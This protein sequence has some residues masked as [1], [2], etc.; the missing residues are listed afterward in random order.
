MIRVFV[1]VSQVLGD[2]FCFKTC[3]EVVLRFVSLILCRIVKLVPSL[4]LIH[5]KG[6]FAIFLHAMT[7]E[8]VQE[9]DFLLVISFQ[10]L[11]DLLISL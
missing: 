6:L 10:A 4:V 3:V 1:L 11:F 5:Q 8:N 2:C 9:E 7:R